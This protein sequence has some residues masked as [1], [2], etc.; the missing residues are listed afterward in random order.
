MSRDYALEGRI[1]Q[2]AADAGAVDTALDEFAMDHIDSANPLRPSDAEIAAHVEKMRK[3][4][5]HRWGGAGDENRELFIQAF[6]PSRSLTAQGEV[7]KLI[8][9][10]RARV[11]AAQFGTTLSGKPG[12]VPEHYKTRAEGEKGKTNPWSDDPSNLDA[13]GRYNQAALTR[14][15]MVVKSSLTLAKSLAKSAHAFVG[16]TRPNSKAA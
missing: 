15:A 13:R 1:K 5:P 2:A 10:E 3:E 14:Q 4:K 11:V 7:V 6:G 12:T 9:E 8:G 16:A